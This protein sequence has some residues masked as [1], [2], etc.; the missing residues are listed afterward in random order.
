MKIPVVVDGLKCE[1]EISRIS[2]FI[3]LASMAIHYN[4]PAKWYFFRCKNITH[5][6]YRDRDYLNIPI[7][8]I[9]FGKMYREGLHQWV[10]DRLN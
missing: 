8:G 4:N 5:P 1:A 9:L 10:V 2:W 7:D 3:A 6:N